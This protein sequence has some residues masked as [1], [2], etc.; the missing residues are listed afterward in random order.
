M[1]YVIIILALVF[2]SC[3]P[4][5]YLKRSQRLER[6]AI[7]MGA[8]VKQDTV[9]KSVEVITPSVKL[10][11]LV[12]QVN[13]RDTIYVTKD[14]IVTKIKV[15]T[16]TNTVYESVKCP[17]DTVKIKVPIYIK[18]TIKTTSVMKWWWLL[19][20]LAAG[21]MVRL[22]TTSNFNIINRLR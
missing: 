21:Y 1:K 20:A 12:Q 9:Y 14:K 2:S 4:N 5:Y 6:K 13:F 22:L 10:D 17:S 18:K 8:E 19:I 11:T 16:K 7:L 15:N 3:G